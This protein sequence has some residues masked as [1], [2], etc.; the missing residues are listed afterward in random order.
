M[1]GGTC[2][3]IFPGLTIAN[4]LIKK[5]WHVVWVG[6]RNRMESEIIPK[7]RIPIEYINIDVIKKTFLV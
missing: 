4:E 1:A 3:H 6:V 5:G 7:T 2:G